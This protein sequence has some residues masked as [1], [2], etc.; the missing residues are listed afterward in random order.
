MV[1]LVLFVVVAHFILYV[2]DQEKSTA[3]YRR[4]LD[5]EPTLNV[6]GMTEFR[7]N[8]GAVLGLMPSEGIR[9][10]LARD[11]GEFARAGLGRAELYLRVDDPASFIR[12]AL[13]LS[14]TELSALA[15][16]DWGDDAGY[17]LDPDGYVVAFAVRSSAGET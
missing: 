14:A 15:S 4:V 5:M 2:T 9:R 6:P 10:L 16:R 3:F 11:S 8:S 7:L 13:D 12:R 1:P 17:I